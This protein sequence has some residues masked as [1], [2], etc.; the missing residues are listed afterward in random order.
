VKT[1]APS[2]SQPGTENSRL[3]ELLAGSANMGHLII[4][5]GSEGIDVLQLLLE[6]QVA[7]A[8]IRRFEYAD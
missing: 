1:A 5:L 3:V 7:V 2:S 8:Y 4:E 6:S